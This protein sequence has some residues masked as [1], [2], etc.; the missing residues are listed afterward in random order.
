MK[1]DKPIA[2][3]IPIERRILFLRGQRVLIDADLAFIYGVTTKALNQ[4]VKRNHKRFPEDFLFQLT[5]P[6]KE[7]VVTM[8]DHL[9]KLKYSPQLPF[10]FTEHGAIMVAT[11]L[12]SDQ[13][14][15]MSLY[16]VRAFV[17][18][19]RLLASHEDLARKLESLEKKYDAQF[20][21]VF[22]AIRE[23][24]KPPEKPKRKI[25]FIDEG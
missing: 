9:P 11:I 17:R 20:K 16:V 4:A 14:I 10:A 13:A 7:E 25:G 5:Q 18:L 1:P 19:R 8:C 15:E 3:S 21:I 22:D 24:M 12:N 23:L 2:L 6:E